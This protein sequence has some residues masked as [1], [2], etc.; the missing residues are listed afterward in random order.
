MA[1]K[2]MGHNKQKRTTGYNSSHPSLNARMPPEA[3]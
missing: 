3:S 2:H 1:F